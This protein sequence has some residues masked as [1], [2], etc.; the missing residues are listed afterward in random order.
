MCAVFMYLASM[1]SLGHIAT[2]FVAD[3]LLH[4]LS[5]MILL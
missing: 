1:L 5:G 3:L 4:S 2:L